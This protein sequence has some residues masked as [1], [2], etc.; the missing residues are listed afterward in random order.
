M[1]MVD[2]AID[3]KTFL[4]GVDIQDGSKADKEL[5]VLRVLGGAKA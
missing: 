5:S 3:V 2:L 1:K 4:I